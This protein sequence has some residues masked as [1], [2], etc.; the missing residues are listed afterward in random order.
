MLPR[1][2]TAEAF[3]ARSAEVLRR[4]AEGTPHRWYYFG[5]MRLKKVK[6]GDAI[7]ERSC[8]FARMVTGMVLLF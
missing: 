2:R 8:A 6:E 7:R 4:Y 3:F 5:G 1:Q